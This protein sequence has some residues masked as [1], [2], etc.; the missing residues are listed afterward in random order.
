MALRVPKAELPTELSENM[1]KQLGA[2]PEPVEVVY[3]NPDV[4]MSNLEFS[5]KVAAWDA[6]D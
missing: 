1:I 3:N 6:A 4:A 5:A 2:V